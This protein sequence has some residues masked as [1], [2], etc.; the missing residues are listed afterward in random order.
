MLFSK[1]EL[2]EQITHCSVKSQKEGRVPEG[3][4]V[5]VCV[6]GETPAGRGQVEAHDEKDDGGEVCTP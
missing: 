6:V 4:C 1:W 5:Y 3:W 2:N